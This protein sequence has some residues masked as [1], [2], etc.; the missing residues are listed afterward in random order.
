MTMKAAGE[1]QREEKKRQYIKEWIQQKGM[2]FSC[3]QKNTPKK[4]RETHGWREGKRQRAEAVGDSG[5][6]N[7]LSLC[8]TD[9]KAVM[10]G[11]KRCSREE[12]GER[13]VEMMRIWCQGIKTKTSSR[14][15]QH[16]GRE[17]IL[18]NR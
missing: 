2:G 5:T 8:K 15:R 1:A 6:S 9:R 13:V 3:G 17:G 4:K 10:R 12:G 14:H 7:M 11:L 16:P 18:L